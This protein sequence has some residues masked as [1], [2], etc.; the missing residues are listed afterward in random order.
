MPGVKGQKNPSKH[1]RKNGYMVGTQ[2]PIR[3]PEVFSFK[4]FPEDHARVKAELEENGWSKQE[5]VDHLIDH[6]YGE[7]RES[8]IDESD[9]TPADEKTEKSEPD[10]DELKKSV[11][12]RFKLGRQSATYKKIDQ[13]LDL[14]ISEVSDG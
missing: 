10:W 4:L 6:Y 1:P 11:L 14:L 5:W 8:G 12:S 3:V 7:Q 13:A 2:Q 9:R